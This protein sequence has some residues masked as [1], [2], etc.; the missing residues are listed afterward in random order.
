MSIETQP[1]SV[2]QTDQYEKCGWRWWLQRGERVT[3][4]PAAWSHHGNAFHTAAEAVERSGRTMSAEEAVD[5]FSDEYATLTNAALDREPN[6]D[7]WLAAGY[8]GGEDIERRYVL[9]QEQTARYVEWSTEEKP[10][11]WAEP[12]EGEPALELYFLVELGGIQVRGYIDQLIEEP[13]GTVRVRDLKT[14]T[15]RSHF[16][17]QTYAAAVE[18]A[19]GAK[20][21]RG[22]WYLGKTG[23]LSRPVRLDAVNADE[24]GERYAA[25]DAGV[26]AGRFPAN[27]GFNCRFCDVSHA[28][29]FF[30]SRS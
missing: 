19:W 18:Q 9:G 3:P 20:V 14:G 16:Q 4:R 2:S 6:T 13:D 1:R 26:K 17:L 30:S 10:A 8:S 22:D 12:A 25:M 24:L 11:I 27:P 23:R 15:T 5:L 7:R 29:S 28:C 21:D